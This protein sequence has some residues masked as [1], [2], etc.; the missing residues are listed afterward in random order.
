MLKGYARAS[1][2]KQTIDRQLDELAAAGVRQDEFIRRKLQ[3][4]SA[5]GQS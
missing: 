1:L 5:T 3:A 4:P 2:E